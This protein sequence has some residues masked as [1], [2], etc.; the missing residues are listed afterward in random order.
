MNLTAEFNT[1]LLPHGHTLFGNCHASTLVALP[2]G[3]LLAAFF[4]GLREGEPDCAIWLARHH[5]GA[6][7][8]PTRAFAEPGLPH[9]NPVLHAEDDHVW[10][11][12]KVGP[13][14]HDWTTRLAASPDAGQT[15]NTPRPLVPGDPTPRGPV[16]NKLVVLAN[17]DWL[18]PASI[19]TTRLWDAFVDRSTDHGRTWTRADI[20]LDHQPPTTPENPTNALW[21]GL[22]ANALWETS[23][24]TVLQWDGIIQPTLWESSPGHVHLLARSTRGHAYRSDSSDAGHTWSAAYP[25]S[26]PNNNSGLDLT[27]LPGGQLVLAY[28]PVEGNWG[29]RT[30]I[31]LAASNDD[32]ATWTRILD[33]ESRDGEFS[34]PAII[35]NEGRLHVTYTAD[36][37]NII[38]RTYRIDA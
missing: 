6:W 29:R 3:D 1:T 20:P 33:M 14:V 9:W 4:A 22:A 36:R 15:W 19:E 27:R 28:N 18:A 5:A 31:S 7:Q 16:K 24:D 25:T 30:P 10:L 26:L 35:A 21:P 2:N 12:Y 8:P 32:G 37:R 11:F 23:L 38:H 34:Y 17:G 13:T